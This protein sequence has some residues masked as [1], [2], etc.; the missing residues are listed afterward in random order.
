LASTL[1]QNSIIFCLAVPFLIPF[2]KKYAKQIPIVQIIA[3]LIFLLYFYN[4][5]ELLPVSLVFGGWHLQ[6]GVEV[7]FNMDSLL[8]LA[9]TYI[10][11]FCVIIYSS[12]KDYS[13]KFYFLI[14]L[15]LSDLTCLFLANDLFNIYVTLELM[16]LISYL[17][18][19]I[20]LKN[21]QI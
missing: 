16:S 20:E 10:V 11:F 14:N 2:L 1:L 13:W 4:N 6:N 3:F 12:K 5:K 15:L 17:L 21:K 7:F 19:S 18:I 9:A 8:F